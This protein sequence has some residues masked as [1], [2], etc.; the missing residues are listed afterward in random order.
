M[1][2]SKRSR[3]SPGTTA[4]IV[5][6]SNIS[7]LSWA[8]AG[9]RRHKLMASTPRRRQ[10]R[11]T[12]P[13]STPPPAHTQPS[14]PTSGASTSARSRQQVLRR[15]ARSIDE[16]IDRELVKIL[17]S[18]KRFL[19]FTDACTGQEH[20]FG[21]FGSSLRKKVWNRRAKLI[22]LQKQDPLAFLELT[23]E[24]LPTRTANASQPESPESSS[25]A[26]EE[27]SEA[28]SPPSSRTQQLQRP[29]EPVAPTTM[30]S[31]AYYKKDRLD[32]TVLHCQCVS[33][34]FL[35]LS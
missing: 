35:L 22:A 34:C 33:P 13:T 32:G 1:I 27:S 3:L 8:A 26:F 30:S 29:E 5:L 9:A 2:N 28:S 6:A 12:S 24:L 17:L 20:L 23:E 14:T 31:P 11:D 7:W 25:S 15:N 16:S 21:E 19:K 4:C 18:A 10:Q